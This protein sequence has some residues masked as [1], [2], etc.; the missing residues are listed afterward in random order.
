MSTS[1]PT[2]LQATD[3]Y[4]DVA[5]ET[6]DFMLKEMSQDHLFYSA[7]DADTEGEEG[8]YF[9]YTYDKALR[10][11]EKAGIPTKAHESLAKAL[12]ITKHGNFEGKNI[13]RVNDPKSIDIPYYHEAIQALSKRREKR[14]HPFIDKKILVSWNAMMITSLLKASRVDKS[15][16]NTAIKSLDALLQSMYVNSEL[17]PLYTLR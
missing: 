13:V 12:H 15:Y 7:S 3:F 5:F 8:K 2:T 14:V 16:L 1:E 4:K 10:S 11:F 17:Y 9:V 6:I